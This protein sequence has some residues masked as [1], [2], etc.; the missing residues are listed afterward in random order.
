MVGFT[1]MYLYFYFRSS[2]SCNP[3]LA[4]LLHLK[5]TWS[6]MIEINW[7]SWR[8]EAFPYFVIFRTS[9]SFLSAQ[10]PRKLLVQKYHRRSPFQAATREWNK[11]SSFFLIPLAQSKQIS[12][13][14]F[15]ET[16]MFDCFC[17]IVPFKC[18]TFEWRH[19]L[20]SAKRKWKPCK[21]DKSTSCDF[22]ARSSD[23]RPKNHA[24]LAT[25]FSP[26]ILVR[27][28]CGKSSL[29]T[30][31]LLGFMFPPEYPKAPKLG[32]WLFLVMIND[33]KLPDESFFKWKRVDDTP[34][35]EVILPSQSSHL[36]LTVDHVNNWSR[37]NLFQLNPSKCKE[38]HICFFWAKDVVPRQIKPGILN[39]T[40]RRGQG[41][42]S[43]C[44]FVSCR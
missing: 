25:T 24:S 7:L 22:V 28:T 8:F 19:H 29:G 41:N 14:D 44:A 5:P 35:S 12:S 9:V 43:I 26:G 16:N 31:F 40:I 13:F 38:L 21:P 27:S 10:L 17:R 42:F 4:R 36:Q 37:D 34:I 1:K 23:S 6:F 18:R 20:F 30:V 2:M 33:L 11:L 32:P 15:G 39:L 3:G